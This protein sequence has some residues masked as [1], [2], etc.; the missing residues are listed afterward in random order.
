MSEP[1]TYREYWDQVEAIA[2]DVTREAREESRDIWDVLHEAIDG[3]QYVIYTYQA[4]FVLLHSSNEDEIFESGS[5]MGDWESMS[6]VY[7]QAAY[8]ALLADVR[9]HSEFNAESDDDDD[10]ESGEG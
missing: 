9:D 6:D 3:H 2:K 8:H 7:T 5:Y 10:D 1:L 4:R